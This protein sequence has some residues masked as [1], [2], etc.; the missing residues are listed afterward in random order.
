M[1][2]SSLKQDPNALRLS[3]FDVTEPLAAYSKHGFDL[4]GACWPSVEHYFQAS[5]F[6]SESYREKIRLADHP[7]KATKLGQTWLKPKRKDW[8]AKRLLMM[9]RAVYTKCRTH[10]DV[11]ELLLAS[12][13]RQIIDS[14]QFD[15]FWGI[16]RDGR[17]ENGYGQVLEAVRQR[18]R[19]E[20][21]T[22]P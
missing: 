22:Q 10:E 18:L 7:A 5:Q 19:Q 12:G 11:A 8:Q 13:D 17:G 1:I 6:G 2:F 15:Y 4:D 14:S 20:R 9:T 3:R 21:Q 16:G